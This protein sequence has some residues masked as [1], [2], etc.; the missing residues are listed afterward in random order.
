MPSAAIRNFA[1]NTSTG[2]GQWITVRQLNDGFDR[3]TLTIL[4]DALCIA[5][6]EL[7]PKLELMRV[8]CL[9]CGQTKLHLREQ[10]KLSSSDNPT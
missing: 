2:S 4:D 10:P 3:A 9:F 7:D 5:Y 6:A 1:N 8:D